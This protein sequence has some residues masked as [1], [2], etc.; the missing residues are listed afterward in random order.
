MNK[1]ILSLCIASTMLLSALPTTVLAASVGSTDTDKNI[2][3]D[4]VQNQQTQYANFHESNA[5]T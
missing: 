1:K 3:S 4:S 5:E 2:G